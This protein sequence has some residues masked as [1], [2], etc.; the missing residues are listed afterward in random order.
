MDALPASQLRALFLVFIACLLASLSDSSRA[1]EKYGGLG[2]GDVEMGIGERVGGPASLR[3]SGEF[4]RV[5][6]EF[7]SDGA[8][9]DTR[10]KFSNLGQGCCR[11]RDA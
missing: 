11:H 10:L 7:E 1:T 6:R 3:V 4:L 9:Y 2:T 5:S 8:T